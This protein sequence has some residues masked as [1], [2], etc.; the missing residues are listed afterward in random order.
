MVEATKG[1]AKET[2]TDDAIEAMR[3]TP[4]TPAQQQLLDQQ[5][6]AWQQHH[7][8][9]QG[10]G[11]GHGENVHIMGLSHNRDAMNRNYDMFVQNTPH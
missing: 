5:Q 7:E 10:L 6:R 8:Q 9:Q 3:L 2:L 11:G 1:P 4:S